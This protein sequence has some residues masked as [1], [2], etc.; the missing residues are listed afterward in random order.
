[1]QV[2]QQSGGRKIEQT[3]RLAVAIKEENS[4][5]HAAILQTI[6]VGL[7]GG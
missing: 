3:Q 5:V 1:L 6:A 4:D 2:Y 7:F